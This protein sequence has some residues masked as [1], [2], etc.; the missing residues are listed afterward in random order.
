[1]A[2]KLFVTATGTDVGKTYVSALI[3]KKMRAEGFNCG[4]FKPVMSGVILKNGRLEESDCNYVVNTAKIPSLAEDC[5]S[6]YW[7][8]AVSPHLASQRSGTKV[9]INK[10]KS[11]LKK[12]EKKFDYILIEGAGG[13]TCP[14]KLDDEEYL[15]K[16]LILELGA[17]IVIVADGGL[18]TINGTLLTYKYALNNGIK[19]AGIILNNYDPKN[20]MHI[21]NRKQIERLCNT[22]VTASVLKDGKDIELIEHLFKE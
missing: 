12:L 17:D 9:D 19:T 11:D 4:Y 14:I 20:F 2:K 22:A 3:V 13:I 8:E 15:L 16:D 18:G 10:I 6:Y 7:Q 1:M 5:V 21:D